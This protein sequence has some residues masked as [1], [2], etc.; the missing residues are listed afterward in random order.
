M[1]VSDIIKSSMR[2]INVLASGE[3]PSAEEY[4]DV[5]STFQVMLRYWSSRRLLVY[6]STKDTFTLS[7]PTS[8]YSWGTGG[9]INSTRPHQVIGGYI[10]DS[11]GVTHIIDLISEGK[12]RSISVKSTI[13]RP[14]VMYFHPLYPLANLY[15]YPVPDTA[16]VVNLDSFKLFT[17]TSSFDSVNST[18]AFPLQYQEPM[19]Y[20]LSI[21]IA[22][23]FGK[24]IPVEVA[25]IAKEGFDALMALNAANQIEP[26]NI[27]VPASTSYGARYSINSDTYH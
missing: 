6:A 8:V 25:A 14:Y 22:P 24:A 9:L 4:A 10:V 5:L 27:L 17:E 23:E 19:I 11:E 3:L 21:R 1:L 7:P 2:K 12:Y 13:S 15:M 20:N 18:L 26:V 16:E